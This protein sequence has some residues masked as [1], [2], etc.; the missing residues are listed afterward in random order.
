[1]EKRKHVITDKEIKKKS[2]ERLAAVKGDAMDRRVKTT[3]PDRRVCA[4]LVSHTS[5][6][7]RISF[8]LQNSLTCLHKLYF[9]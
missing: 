5:A 1:M 4:G 9:T 7:N 6:F 8:I 2:K 3:S